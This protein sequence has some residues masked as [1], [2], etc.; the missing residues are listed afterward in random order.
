MGTKF[1]FVTILG[2]AA[3]AA[4]PANENF[5]QVM[6]RQVGK[7]ADDADFYP[8]LYR[9]KPANSLR[10]PNGNTREEYA[11]GRG[12]KCKLYFV[13]T[14]ESRRVV[15]WSSDGDTSDCVIARDGR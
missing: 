7:S 9:L 14:P 1:I 2:L 11:A 4:N 6:Q 13:T 5:R 12:G 3:C 8:T 10:L 15:G